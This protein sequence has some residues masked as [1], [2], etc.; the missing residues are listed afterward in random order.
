VTTLT[1]KE[2]SFSAH[3]FGNPIRYVLKAPSEPKSVSSFEAVRSRAKQY[4]RTQ[5]VIC[6]TLAAKILC[7]DRLLDTTPRI[8]GCQRPYGLQTSTHILP[9]KG[10]APDFPCPL[11]RAILVR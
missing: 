11:Q 6:D 2:V 10:G 8:F 4:R 3:A 1:F 9:W 5:R 7:A